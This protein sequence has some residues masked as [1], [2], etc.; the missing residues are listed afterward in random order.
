MKTNNHLSGVLFSVLGAITFSSKAVLV[1]MAYQVA[2]IDSITLLFLRMVIALPFF[3]SIFLLEN[4]RASRRLTAKEVGYILLFSFLGYYFASLCDFIGLQYIPASFERL[5]LFVYP[6]MV[7]IINRIVCKK[8]ITKKQLFA[9]VLTYIGIFVTFSDQL[10]IDGNE[11]FYFGAALILL[12]ALAYAIFLV[13]SGNYIPK[14]GSRRFASLSMSGAA[15]FTSFHFFIKGGVSGVLSYSSDLYILAFLIAIICT[16]IPS[17]L[18][19]EG[20]RRIGSSN[21]SVVASIGPVSTI[22]LAVILLEEKVT[23][24]QIIGTV[25]VMTGIVVLTVLKPKKD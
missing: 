10:D 14:L 18:V 2:D 11:T 9:I 8:V 22:I 16:V 7:V 17:F 4:R 21:M 25:V 6:T 15:G 12:S 20:I 13:S 19:A 1:K 5:L 24:Y 3:I 23:I